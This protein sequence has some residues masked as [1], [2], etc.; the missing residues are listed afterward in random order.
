MHRVDRPTPMSN[1]P[2]LGDITKTFKV[3]HPFHPWHGHEF[4]LVTCHQKSGEVLLFFKDDRDRLR[5][6]PAQWTDVCPPDPYEAIA[7]RQSHFRLLDLIELSRLVNQFNNENSGR[8]GN[9][10][11]KRV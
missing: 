3:T 11:R 9:K 6:M 10:K 2:G 5:T 7:D 8:G 1:A 4:E